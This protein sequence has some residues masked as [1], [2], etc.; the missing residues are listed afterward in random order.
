MF[1]SVR[2]AKLRSMNE[3]TWYP[4]LKCPLPDD[5]KIGLQCA[6]VC[7]GPRHEH[8]CACGQE[9]VFFPT[10]VLDRDRYPHRAEGCGY[11][12]PEA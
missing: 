9:D 5:R 11:G 2:N 4:P 3:C 1:E 7:P 8:P 10:T 6:E 12:S